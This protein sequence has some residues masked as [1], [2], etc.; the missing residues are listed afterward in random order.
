MM[1]MLYQMVLFYV[2]NDYFKNDLIEGLFKMKTGSVVKYNPVS[3]K[4]GIAVDKISFANGV[5]ATNTDLYVSATLQNK[6]FH[7]KIQDNRYTLLSR[8]GFY[9][10]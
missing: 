8:H 3:N 10:R 6:L 9:R 5:Y 7:Y 4:W 1:Y 2:T